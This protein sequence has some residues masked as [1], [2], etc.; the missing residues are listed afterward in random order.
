LEGIFPLAP[1]GLQVE[2]AFQF[3]LVGLQPGPSHHLQQQG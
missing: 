2:L 1:Q 3:D